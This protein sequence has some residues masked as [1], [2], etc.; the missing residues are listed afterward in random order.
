MGSLTHE[1]PLVIF[2]IAA[3]M[4]V[5]S[6]IVLGLVHVFNARVPASTMDRI[7]DPALFAIGPLLLLGFI[8]STFHLG[9]PMRAIN[10]LG[11]VGTSWLSNEILA[12]SVFL[13][14]GAA[15]ALM[16]WRKIGTPRLR[17]LVAVLAA[18]CGVVLVLCISQVY[19]LRTVPAW[20]TWHTPVRFWSTTLMLG[21]LAVGAVLSLTALRSGHSHTK[22]AA[23]ATSKERSL[24]GATAGS[25]STSAT[26]I[27]ADRP[28]EAHL[29]DP[30][31]DRE[32][33]DDDVAEALLMR[34]I[35][36]ITIGAVAILGLGFVAMPV[37]LAQLGSHPDPAAAMSLSV[38]TEMHPGLAILYPL[39]IAAG[40]VVLA[41][42]LSHLGR[43]RGDTSRRTVASMAVL[44]F[45]LVLAGEVLGRM[46]FYASMF[47]TGL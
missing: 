40:V 27:E 10:A 22:D 31:T 33:A 38:F 3:Q 34:T 41:I 39:L 35:R 24:V 1:L 9:S 6:F 37:Y 8:A 26:A 25:G 14:L 17:Q 20:D 36:G 11:H 29:D 45:F 7:A 42:L 15:F 12:G 5:G 30:R 46:F 4:S 28:D 13:V 19:S 16:Q 32:R 18:L 47:R 2:T 44:A 21:S 23:R 43:R